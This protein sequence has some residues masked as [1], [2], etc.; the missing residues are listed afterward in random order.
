MASIKKQKN[1]KFLVRVSYKD[2]IT[3]KYR[4]KNKTF[5]RKREAEQ[6]S[7]QLELDK[8]SSDLGQRDIS[9]YDYYIK[10]KDTYRTTNVSTNTINRYNHFGDVVKDYFGDTQ[11]IDISKMQYQEF[12]NYFGKTHAK[13]T[14]SRFNSYFRSMAKEAVDDNI[15][16]SDFTRNAKIHFGV[17]ARDADAKFLEMSDFE[18]LMKYSKLRAS[19]LNTS[20]L[21]IYF[22]CKTGARY[23][24]AAGLP[25]DC[26]DFKNNTIRFKQA[27]LIHDKKIGKLKNKYSYRTIQVNQKLMDMLADQKEQ[28][29][30][31]YKANNKINKDNLVFRNKKLENPGNTDMNTML[32]K[33]ENE[34]GISKMIRVHDLRHTHV[35]YLH[36]HG[37]DWLYI[38]KRIG[39]A[40]IQTPL[41]VYT[42]LMKQTVVES[43]KD[44][45]TLLDKD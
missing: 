21:E 44:I 40:N 17:D 9:F 23:E 38:S 35:S 22:I 30:L 43:D 26:V 45:E 32:H 34:C 4:T 27:W 12:L 18:K 14:V 24:E 29:E 28:Q 36:A 33:L 16:N 2:P 37:Y 5:I 41:H 3:K 7:R 19:F 31:Y 10:W 42:H 15:I 8:Q 13:D 25:W 39:H 6:Y 1:G 11:L 20:A